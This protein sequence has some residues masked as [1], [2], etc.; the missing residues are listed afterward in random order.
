MQA[1]QEHN[2]MLEEHPCLFLAAKPMDSN[3]TPH[4]MLLGTP[5]R[6]NLGL[7]KTANRPSVTS[8]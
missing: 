6:N 1:W 3:C 4:D 8:S 5:V 2:G 7:D